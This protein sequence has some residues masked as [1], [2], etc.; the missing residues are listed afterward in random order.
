MGYDATSINA[1]AARAGVGKDTVYRRWSGKAELVYEAVFTVTDTAP[2]PDT[3]TIENDVTVLVQGLVDEF[4]T[5]AAAAALPGVLADFAADPALRDR[6]RATFLMPAKER[7]LSVFGR[8]AER[9]ETVAA[10]PADLLLDTLVGAVFFHL[11]I[12]GE[13]PDRELAQRIAALVTKGIETR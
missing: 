4:S 7:L 11:G 9:G 13:R 8:A 6:I 1:V 2:V 5:P 3:G 10:V 12:L